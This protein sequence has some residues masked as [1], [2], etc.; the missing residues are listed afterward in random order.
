MWN[1]ALR[2]H[3]DN[4]SINTPRSLRRLRRWSLALLCNLRGSDYSLCKRLLDVTVSLL[5]LVGLLPLFAIVAVLIKLTDRGPVL[6]WQTR[7]GRWGREFAFPKFRSMVPDAERRL[8]ELLSQNDHPDGVVFKMKTDPRMTWIGR[9]IRRT[10]IDELPQ[11][12]CVLKGEMSL[13]GPRPPVPREVA[14]YQLADRRR[15]DVPPGLTCLW[16]VSGRSLLPFPKQVELD[17]EYIE[18]RSLWLDLKLLLRTIP[19]VVFGEGAF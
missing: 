6:F 16:Q 12:W 3:A 10:S 5:L 18:N 8:K 7:V 9:I 15:L 1:E 17:L 2:H 19:A 14:Q 13:V 4:P 11:L